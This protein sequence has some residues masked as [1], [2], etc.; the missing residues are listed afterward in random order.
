MKD[1]V[2]EGASKVA[3]G[4]DAASAQIYAAVDE[5]MDSLT[6]GFG[7]PAATPDAKDVKQAL[8]FGGSGTKGDEPAT[9]ATPAAAPEAEVDYYAFTK[10]TLLWV[11][12]VRSAFYLVCGVVALLAA[13]YMLGHNI[14]L[15]TVVAYLTLAQMALNFLRHAINPSLQQKATWLDSAW[16]AAAIQQLGTGI[17]A[18]AAVHDRH[19]SAGNPHKHLIIAMS[20]WLVSLL[21]KLVPPMTLLL[22]LYIGAF[23]V[24]KAYDLLKPKVDPVAKDV[25]GQVKSKWDVADHRIKA[26]AIMVLILLLGCVSTI[27]LVIAAFVVFVFA[28]SQ[29]PK[30]MEQLGKKV[31]PVLTPVGN[32]AA[33]AGSKVSNMLIGASNKFELTPT[34]LKAKKE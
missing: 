17:K 24:P 14:P 7:S 16:T 11:H 23:I 1:I 2:S 31:G 20:L 3:Q 27:D 6:Q 12:P 5:T 13:D 21:C 10:D 29:L 25:Y 9:P 8:N 34:P 33:A 18:L 28:H 22:G 32:T 15:L 30:E 26:G 4:A 19:L